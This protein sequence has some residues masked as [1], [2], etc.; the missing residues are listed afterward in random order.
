MTSKSFAES[1]LDALWNL[2]SRLYSPK[3][4]KTVSPTSPC[5]NE[6]SNTE[7]IMIPATPPT[8]PIHAE[9]FSTFVEEGE[10]CNLR[11]DIAIVVTKPSPPRTLGNSASCVFNKTFMCESNSTRISAFTRQRIDVYLNADRDEQFREDET[12]LGNSYS[13]NNNSSPA[14]LRSTSFA[15]VSPTA[16]KK[17]KTVA[18]ERMELENQRANEGITRRNK[19]NSQLEYERTLGASAGCETNTIE[20]IKQ[21]QSFQFG[22]Q[23]D[24]YANY[25]ASDFLYDSDFYVRNY[26]QQHYKRSISKTFEHD[27]MQQQ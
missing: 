2:G 5:E 27:N 7:Q 19:T 17:G 3:K 23:N 21:L 10:T 1:L 8:S 24:S 6:Y 16:A 25:T 11:N 22:S 14:L 9:N 4:F 18:I 20:L 12:S 15:R 26:A 13:R